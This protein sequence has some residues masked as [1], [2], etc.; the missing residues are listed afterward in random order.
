MQQDVR[1][2]LVSVK[3]LRPHPKNSRHHGKENIEGIKKSIKTFGQVTPLVVGHKNFVLKGCGT[4]RALE[5]LEIPKARI[6]RVSM[7]REEEIKYAIADNRT[8]DMSRFD[9]G[10]MAEA[11]RPMRLKE[12]DLT[13]TGF[14]EAELKPLFE[15][16]WER[17][18]EPEDNHV[19]LKNRVAFVREEW[20]LLEMTAQRVE[21]SV[22]DMLIISVKRYARYLDKKEEEK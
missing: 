2:E 7:S 15:A 20:E 13:V 21:Q 8:G 3:V 9:F 10:K 6:I 5:E 22:H 1:V 14:S 16:A 4:L 18:E 17:P 11:L 19:L 12:Q